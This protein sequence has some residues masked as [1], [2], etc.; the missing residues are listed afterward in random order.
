MLDEI[1]K[2]IKKTLNSLNNLQN[3]YHVKNYAKEN[4]EIEE[5]GCLLLSEFKCTELIH[6]FLVKRNT[7]P[8]LSCIGT[9][10]PYLAF[11]QKAGTVAKW[12]EHS[13]R[14]WKVRGFNFG[15]VKSKTEQLAAAASLVTVHHLRPI[16]QVWLT[17]YQFNVTGSGVMFICDMVFGVL[18]H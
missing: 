15:C 12:V 1:T 3:L 6:G 14:V 8:S 17:Q 13:P 11:Y 16:E 5:T 18:A 4:V 7:F 10:G 9:Q 2:N